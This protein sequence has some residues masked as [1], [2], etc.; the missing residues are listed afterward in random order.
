VEKKK[1]WRKIG[2]TFFKKMIAK[3]GNSFGSEKV[4]SAF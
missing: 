4:K 1:M 3:N 2:I